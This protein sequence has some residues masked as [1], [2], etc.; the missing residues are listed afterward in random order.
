[1]YFTRCE[2]SNTGSVR[3]HGC[4]L[5]LY[6]LLLRIFIASRPSSAVSQSD[7]QN[8]EYRS[9][10]NIF[11]YIVTSA[12]CIQFQIC[13]LWNLTSISR[14]PGQASQPFYQIA[15]FRTTLSPVPRHRPSFPP[16]RRDTA[17]STSRVKES[18]PRYLS[19]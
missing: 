8:M 19:R 2:D 16:F 17:S 15:K 5:Q 6:L 11:Q 3:V 18:P 10:V 9:S 4:R 14:F 13:F 12:G 7:R 1:M